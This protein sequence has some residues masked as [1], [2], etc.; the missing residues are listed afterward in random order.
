MLSLKRSSATRAAFMKISVAKP[1][2]SSD[3][4]HTH[5]SQEKEP[6]TGLG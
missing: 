6:E 5:A 1:N 3:W 2:P 4:H